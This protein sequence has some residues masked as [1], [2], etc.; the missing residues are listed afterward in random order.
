MQKQFEKEQVN[1]SI[2]AS[3]LGKSEKFGEYTNS[4]SHIALSITASICPLVKLRS[5]L[6]ALCLMCRVE[7]NQIP[8][9]WLLL[10][11]DKSGDPLYSEEQILH[12]QLEL[13][14]GSCSS[15]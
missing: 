6:P 8:H 3:L 10:A 1:P 9:P 4:I 14:S 13:V 15:V 2:P 12:Q 5:L 7:W 11:A